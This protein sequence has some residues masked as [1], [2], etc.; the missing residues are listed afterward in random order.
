[1]PPLSPTWIV[2][3]HAPVAIHAV[4]LVNDGKDLIV[5]DAKGRISVTSMSNFRP[6]VFWQAHQDTILR[7]DAW[8]GFLVTYVLSG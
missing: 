5:G 8:Y 6:H 7:A 1:M 3:H 2:R 4:A